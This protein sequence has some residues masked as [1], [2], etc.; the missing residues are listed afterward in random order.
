MDCLEKIWKGSILDSFK[1]QSNG[2]QPIVDDCLHDR[3]DPGR[4]R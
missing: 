3:L 2:S 1:A 4:H